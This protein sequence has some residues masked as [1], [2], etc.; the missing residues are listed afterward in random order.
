MSVLVY[1]KYLFWYII[2][3][4]IIHP[5]TLSIT[6]APTSRGRPIFCFPKLAH[7][8]QIRR[9]GYA[10]QRYSDTA[11]FQKHRYGDIY[12]IFIFI[13]RTSFFLHSRVATLTISMQSCVCP[14]TYLSLGVCSYTNSKILQNDIYEK[15]QKPTCF[16]NI[17]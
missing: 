11:F 16:L 1:N 7:C 15:F 4:K 14:H 10:T 6:P 5:N 3:Y 13:E 9:Y 17:L 12:V 8:S 2:R